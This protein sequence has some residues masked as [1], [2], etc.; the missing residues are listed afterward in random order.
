M[1][2]VQSFH[3]F[4]KVGL[5]KSVH[6]VVG[7]A[8]GSGADSQAGRCD[9]IEIR[10]S[11]RQINHREISVTHYYGSSNPA[12]LHGISMYF[13][14]DCM[15]KSY[16]KKCVLCVHGYHHRGYAALVLFRTEI[17]AMHQLGIFFN[18]RWSSEFS[19]GIAL[20]LQSSP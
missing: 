7:G 11:H 2:L 9:A 10:P 12:S 17:S 4:R 14:R 1:D 19:E 18:S 13:P 15:R 3:L 8:E 16:E 6:L 5:Q 20:R